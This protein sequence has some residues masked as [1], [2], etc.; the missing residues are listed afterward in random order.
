MLTAAVDLI[1]VSQFGSPRPETR[2]K[3][4][5]AR[6]RGGFPSGG[7]SCNRQKYHSDRKS[8]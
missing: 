3:A 8:G 5:T 4:A 7:V 1:V 2:M 6:R